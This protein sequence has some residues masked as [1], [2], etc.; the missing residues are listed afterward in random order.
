MNALESFL[1]GLIPAADLP[2]E[3]MT[4]SRLFPLFYSSLPADHPNKMQ[5]RKSFLTAVA[6]HSMTKNRI[7]E[8]VNAWNKVGITP[9][10][11]KG[12]LMA[13]FL[14]D[15]PANRFY[16]DVDI[17]I[18]EKDAAKACAVARALPGWVEV[19]NRVGT[20]RDFSHEESHVFSTDK[21]I[22]LD[23]H[24]FAVHNFGSRSRLAQ[25][26]T[27]AMWESARE[28]TWENC[29]VMLPSVEDCALV[30]I[31]LARSWAIDDDI[32]IKPNDPTDLSTLSQKWGLTRE[33]FMARANKFGLENV[34]QAYLERCDPWKQQLTLGAVPKECILKWRAAFPKDWR[35]DWNNSYRERLFRVPT[36]GIEM[37]QQIPNLL[38]VKALMRQETNLRTIMERNEP[39]QRLHPDSS[40]GRISRVIRGLSW[41]LRFLGPRIDACVP[42]SLC[43]YHALKAEGHRVEFVSGIKRINN[44]LKGHA[45]VELN[46]FPLEAFGDIQAS[47]MFKENF[48]YPAREQPEIINL[49]QHQQRASL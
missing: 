35:S 43:L 17:L 24:R 30:G 26:I 31:V 48:R 8:L 27:D 6:R 1:L 16:G 25:K 14:Y 44:Q 39:K 11:F 40:M 2:L 49:E 22:A 38:R 10:F 18:Q 5:F 47:L 13:E 28:H 19:W 9:M 42:R 23:L 4:D 12:F 37:L 7:L 45:W 33:S 36:A 41:A 29:K 32:G 34:T 21:N 46:G 3:V 15:T 20:V